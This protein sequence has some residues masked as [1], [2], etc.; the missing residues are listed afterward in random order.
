MLSESFILN[1][2]LSI[3]D[4]YCTKMNI[5]SMQCIVFIKQTMFFLREKSKP[6]FV[7]KTSVRP[8]LKNCGDVNCI[9]RI[10]AYLEQKGAINFG[11]GKSS[12]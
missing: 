7:N 3:K 12:P 11:C 2:Y 8:G 6:S 10:H 1:I 4:V 9:G 5:L